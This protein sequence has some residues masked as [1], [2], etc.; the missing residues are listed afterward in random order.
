[1]DEIMIQVNYDEETPTV[2]CRDLHKALGV[3]TAYKDWFPRMCE[4]GFVEGKDFC[5]FLSES[6]GGRPAYDHRITI[7]M[8]KELCMIQRTDAGKRCRQYFIEVEKRWNTPEAVMARALQLANRQLEEIKKQNQT[9]IATTAIQ[10]QQIEMLQPK[11][12]YTD[13][14][15]KAY[16]CV[17]ITQI[18]KDYGLSGTAL[19]RI[20]AEHRIQY[21]T[22]GQWVL[23][24]K[25]ANCGY[26]KSETERINRHGIP[27]VRIHTKW[28]EKGR[29]FIH[30][31]LK[32]IGILPVNQQETDDP[33]ELP[34]YY[35]K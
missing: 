32:S 1:M 12:D 22:G 11:A 8:A 30:D 16:G 17:N 3:R 2:S 14:I 29:R 4:Y 33:Y 26:V 20:L 23:Y 24:A 27:D 15:L 34:Y 25:Y 5:S 10:S 6:T 9:L 35:D 31:L 13:E 18:A 21:M 19:N 7:D 28:T